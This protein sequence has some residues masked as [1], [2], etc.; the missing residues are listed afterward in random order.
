MQTHNCSTVNLGEIKWGLMKH[1]IEYRAEYLDNN[2]MYMILYNIIILRQ[3]LNF[4][5]PNHVYL[6][7]KPHPGVFPP[8]S[9]QITL[10][11]SRVF[12]CCENK[13]YT[14]S[15]FVPLY[16]TRAAKRGAI[17]RDTCLS[18]WGAFKTLI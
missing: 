8:S 14:S 7:P 1:R 18:M 4:T 6:V 9:N 3:K 10:L 12:D 2:S 16:E 11:L 17:S 15:H 13:C 5:N